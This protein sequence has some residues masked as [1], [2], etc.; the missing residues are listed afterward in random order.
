MFLIQQQ[1]ELPYYQQP[2][3]WA[4]IQGKPHLEKIHVPQCSLQYYCTIYNSQ[5]RKQ[6][7]CPS[8]EGWI[9]MWYVMQWNVTQS[10]KERAAICN[11]MDGPRD[12]RTK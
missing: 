12:Y 11:N 4:Y 8:T 1:I 10:L 5:K 9:K 3:P 6:P 7:K 2:L